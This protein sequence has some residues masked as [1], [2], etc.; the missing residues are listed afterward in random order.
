MGRR[1][2]SRTI[3]SAGATVAIQGE[4]GSFSE[5]AARRLVPEP[6]IACFD[7]FEKVAAAVAAGTAACGVLPVSNSV[8][9]E[10]VDLAGLLQANELIATQEVSLPLEQCLIAARAVP[11]QEVREVRSHPV[12]LGQCRRF[13]EAHPWMAAVPAAD[14]AG[15]VR[16]VCAAGREDLAAI[17][18]RAAADRYGG[19]VLVAGIA[20]RPDNVTRFVLLERAGN[21]GRRNE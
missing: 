2:F 21:S 10:V 16:E 7:S 11:L 20:D 4:P 12:A 9:G 8:V 18:G 6:A 15:A 3:S 14:T 1:G 19:K 5:S 17:A 13:L